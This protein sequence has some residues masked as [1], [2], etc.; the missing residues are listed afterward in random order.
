MLLLLLK[1]VPITMHE[2]RMG[3]SLRGGLDMGR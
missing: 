3:S 2:Y 1:W